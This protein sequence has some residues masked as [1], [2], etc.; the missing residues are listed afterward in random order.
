MNTTAEQIR[1]TPITDLREITAEDQF[2]SYYAAKGLTNT[3]DKIKHLRD[4][5]KIRAVRYENNLTDEEK[6]TGLEEA[7]LYGYW[8]V[9]P[10]Q[11]N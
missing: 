9:L 4:A 8:R 10:D 6:L 5:M 3:A 1:Q 2:E 7:A 11:D